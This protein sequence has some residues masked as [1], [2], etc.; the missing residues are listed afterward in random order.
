MHSQGIIHKMSSQQQSKMRPT[1]APSC[2]FNKTKEE[3]RH[4]CGFGF[5]YTWMNYF[6]KGSE[7]IGNSGCLWGGGLR[8]EAGED[9]SL[10]ALLDALTFIQ[11]KCITYSK[12]WHSNIFRILTLS[13]NGLCT[14]TGTQR[15]RWGKTAF[16]EPCYP[17]AHDS[18]TP[19]EH[20]EIQTQI[21]Q[22]PKQILCLSREPHTCVVL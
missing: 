7:E 13:L 9:F 17:R 22:E 10:C 3:T 12:T 6:R 15:Q 4:K 8:T 16:I 11:G 5:S 18:L 14:Q 21:S 20:Q 2:H 1:R 19:R